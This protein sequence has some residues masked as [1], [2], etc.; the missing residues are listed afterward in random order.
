[1]NSLTDCTSLDLLIILRASRQRHRKCNVA[2]YFCVAS[3]VWS[4]PLGRSVGQSAGR[5]CV[6]KKG[7]K[8]LI[9]IIR[10]SLINHDMSPTSVGPKTHVMIDHDDI[11][12][13]HWNTNFVPLL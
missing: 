6:M 3:R 9:I 12:I 8:V 11:F 2:M 10:C 1:M 5:L 13:G 4:G 7:I